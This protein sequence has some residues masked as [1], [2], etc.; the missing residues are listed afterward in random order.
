MGVF[1]R[2]TGSLKAHSKSAKN[3]LA[4]QVM[5][6]T[7]GQADSQTAASAVETVEEQKTKSMLPSFPRI[8]ETVA[9][10]VVR[11]EKTMKTKELVPV[12][13]VSTNSTGSHLTVYPVGTKATNLIHDYDQDGN[14]TYAEG[15][16]VELVRPAQ[17]EEIARRG[18]I[19]FSSTSEF[20]DWLAES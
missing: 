7:N 15:V 19:T 10:E 17:A 13:T 20:N 11:K 6:K 12:L 9:G 8:A 18:K 14:P 1:Q 3:V 5:E 2:N 16:Y 4:T